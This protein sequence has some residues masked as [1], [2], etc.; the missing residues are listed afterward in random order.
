MT[1]LLAALA[2]VFLVILAGWGA[3]AGKLVGEAA[4]GGVAR[5]AYMILSP[6][7]IFTEILRA[8][9]TFSALT[10]AVVGCAGFAVMGVIGF[11]MLPIAGK[12]GG[13]AFAS[14]HQG[15]VRW[16]T[17]VILAA[18][19]SLLGEPASAL[20]ALLM[21]PAI[22]VVN[23]ITVS[24]HSRWGEGQNPSLTGVL[25]SLATNPLIIA[26][27]AGLAINLSGVEMGQVASDTLAVIGR[28]AL[29]VTLMAVGAGLDLKAIAARPV[30]MSAAVGIKLVVAPLVF[31]GLGL[32]AGLHGLHLWCLALCGAAPSPPAA[33]VLTREMGG[34][35]RFMAG[36]ITATTL[37]SVISIPA[38]LALAKALG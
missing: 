8:D 2:P 23:V 33:Y 14:A 34:D 18:S 38:A 21:G 17:F 35:P 31:I 36:H 9:L 13:H 25:K 3:R 24:V 22:P 7:F 11:A 1:T 12:G 27:L 20:V 10:Y 6:V 32:A 37:L 29:G 30:L 15:V 5:L 4:W 19:L 16:N 28:G 26:C